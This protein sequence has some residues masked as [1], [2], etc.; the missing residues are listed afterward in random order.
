MKPLAIIIL[1]PSA[2]PMAER[3]RQSAPGSRIH[4]LR[5]RL[6]EEAARCDVLYADF[7]DQL[8]ALHAGTEPVVALCAAGI[9]IRA[10]APRLVQDDKLQGAAV[11]ALAPDGSTVVPLLGGLQGANDI[12]RA[13]AA[14]LACQAAITTSGELRFGTCLLQPPAGYRLAD[15]EQGKRVVAGLLA[16]GTVD[17]AGPAPWLEA[18]DLP[19]AE[20]GTYRIQV[21]TAAEAPAA[22]ELRIYPRCVAVAIKSDAA[23]GAEPLQD[24]LRRQLGSAGLAVEALALVLMDAGSQGQQAVAEAC[25]V[26]GC[27]L[28]L[29]EAATDAADLLR[30]ALPD[31]RL[32]PPAS[33]TTLAIAISEQPLD[34]LA[35]GRPRGSLSVIGLGPGHTDYM[36]P[37]ARTAL[38]RATDIL[39]YA[40]YVDMAGPLRPGQR[41]HPSDNREEL[42]R[43]QQ[44][45]ALASQGHQVAIVSSGDPGV[46]AMA[47]ATLE[48]LE[49]GTDPRWHEVELR[50]LPGVS[51]AFATAAAAGAPLGHDCCLLSLSDNLK[52]WSV[53]ERR[54]R[55]AAEADLA[56]AWYNPISRHRPWQL[57]RALEIV[58][59]YRPAS[60]PVL[61]GWNIARPG[62]R[63][64][65][66]TLEALTPDQVDM[67]TLVI[68]G[69]STTR[70]LHGGAG[71]EWVYTPRS[72]PFD[73][74]P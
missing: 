44:A 67:R 37:A 1:G 8:R 62:A 28:R 52:P 65:T 57:A 12:A 60:T 32:L 34:P 6:G 7:G 58:R 16:G 36:I 17:V 53:I 71:Q 68:I 42:Q 54:L 55:L 59:E 69:S 35:V 14:E 72:Y 66:T 9:I 5:G 23:P 13:I 29:L 39:G 61:L 48:A 30:Q 22:H 50:I 38:D 43:A 20:A 64:V 26:L 70:R 73:G 46:F 24:R 18:I 11:L 4:G 31:A 19:R 15:I 10:L 45:F 27:E 51:A 63:L 47:A 56:M 74:E 21:S 49:A 33:D 41:R 40:T 25:R 2:L 3:L